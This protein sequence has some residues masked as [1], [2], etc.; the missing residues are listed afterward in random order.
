MTLYVLDCTD[1]LSTLRIRDLACAIPL[2]CPRCGEHLDPA[3]AIP[4]T[5]NRKAGEKRKAA[6]PVASAPDVT[7]TSA[8][9]RTQTGR[10]V[11]LS[12]VLVVCVFGVV[13]SGF[14]YGFRYL[15]S[16]LNEPTTLASA[17]FPNNVDRPPQFQPPTIPGSAFGG[18]PPGFPRSGLPG[19]AAANSRPTPEAPPARLNPAAAFPIP[20]IQAPANPV[21]ASPDVAQTPDSAPSSTLPGFGAFPG[22]PPAGMGRG[23][24]PSFPRGPSFPTAGNPNGSRF[25][26]PSGF[27]GSPDSPPANP[28]E[29]TPT[30]SQSSPAADNAP[31]QPAPRPGLPTRATPLPELLEILQ[32]TR[33]GQR[34]LPLRLLS[35]AEPTD[36]LR[37]QVL[38]LIADDL[39]E[40]N[41]FLRQTASAAFCRWAGP[42]QNAQLVEFLQN[43]DPLLRDARIESLRTLARLKDQQHHP[44]LVMMLNEP[45]LQRE[46]R[47]ALVGMGADIEQQLLASWPEFTNPIARR[48]LL[49]VLRDVGTAACL[50]LLEQISE[51]PD[52]SVRPAARTALQAVNSR[53]QASGTPAN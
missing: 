26:P 1:C 35:S 43:K 14:W 20:A 7:L 10:G 6:V 38:K 12:V 4:H 52:F 46:V 8:T 44:H 25:R 24:L 47:E 23:R 5:Q 39:Q 45:S 49:E 11:V 40:D 32:A 16:E 51:S 19:S 31:A 13:G 22:G 53:L 17:S 33:G 15:T 36:E 29:A 37:E 50:P 30:N 27:P 9:G 34:S 3:T 18:R 21:T 28:P 48:L 42:E 41:P 2:H